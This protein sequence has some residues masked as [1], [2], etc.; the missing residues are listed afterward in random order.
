M[1]IL[2]FLLLLAPAGSVGAQ[3]KPNR[4]MKDQNYTIS[5]PVNK[6]PEV[7]FAAINNVKGW[8][9]EQI[10]GHTDH[11]NAEFDYHYKDVHR[12]KI[13]ITE[14][15]PGKKVTWLVLQ[16]HFNFTKD[17]TE[18]TGTKIVFEISQQGDKT[19][20]TFTHV[21]LVPAYECFNICS[22]A[23]ANYISGSLKSLIETG[24]GKPNPYETAIKKA[25]ALKGGRNE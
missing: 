4:D 21:G 2:I 9:S 7:V 16:N 17:A 12:C 6:S 20:L 13:R 22:D 25:E 11:L 18:W 10:D 8:W 3:T 24:K 23:W 19:Q 5:F 1:K 14:F 15:I